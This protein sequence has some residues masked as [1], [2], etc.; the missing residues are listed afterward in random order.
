M[1]A[2]AEIDR[3]ERHELLPGFV[4]KCGRLE[5]MSVPFQSK[6]RLRDAMKLRIGLVDQAIPGSRSRSARVRNGSA[7]KRARQR[8]P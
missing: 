2:V 4:Q 3:L 7:L 8:A 6:M 5:K 1:H